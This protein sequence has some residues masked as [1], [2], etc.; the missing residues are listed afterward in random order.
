M[1]HR[2]DIKCNGYFGITDQMYV[3][4]WKKGR[5]RRGNNSLP[6]IQWSRNLASIFSDSSNFRDRVRFFVRAYSIPEYFLAKQWCVMCVDHEM[7]RIK[8]RIQQ[9]YFAW[10][11]RVIFFSP[12]A[13]TYFSDRMLMASSR[14]S[15]IF[16]ATKYSSASET[17][18]LSPFS[19]KPYDAGNS[20]FP[21]LL[22]HFTQ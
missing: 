22:A 11:T 21:R 13:T 9:L 7:A 10:V 4:I 6:M 18:K 3:D 12:Y 1:K 16:S 2:V 14:R 20:F 5:G 19:A 17:R 8:L 15:N